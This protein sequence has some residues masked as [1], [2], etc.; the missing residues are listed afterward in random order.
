MELTTNIKSKN[1]LKVQELVKK[2]NWRFVYVFEN[3]NE[4]HTICLNSNDTENTFEFT[5][6]LYFIDHKYKESTRKYSFFKKLKINFK[7]FFLSF[8]IV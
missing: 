3:I 2:Y 1:L 7:N 5:S 8:N 4:T 6:A